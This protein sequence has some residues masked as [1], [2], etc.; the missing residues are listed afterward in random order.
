MSPSEVDI[1]ICSWVVIGPKAVFVFF[2]FNLVPAGKVY[3]LNLNIR[4]RFLLEIRRINSIS[5]SPHSPWL[6]EGRLVGGTINFPGGGRLARGD[7]DLVLA[8]EGDVSGERFRSIGFLLGIDS[9]L[10][11]ATRKQG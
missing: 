11:S 10:D 7:L 1:T 5:S 3:L 4:C 6:E 9:K 8:G 2:N